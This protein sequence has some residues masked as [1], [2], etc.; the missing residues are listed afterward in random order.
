MRMRIKIYVYI[1]LSV[2][3]EQNKSKNLLLANRIRTKI[4]IMPRTKMLPVVRLLFSVCVCDFDS[5]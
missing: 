5:S 2:E 1:Y 3:Q 4:E